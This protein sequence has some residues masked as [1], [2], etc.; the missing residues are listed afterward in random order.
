M[1][2]LSIA[3]VSVALLVLG[4]CSTT[5]TVG[6]VVPLPALPSRLAV[7]CQDPGV[8]AGNPY[9]IELANNRKALAA[10]ARKQRDTVS[11]YNDLRSRLKK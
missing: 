8:K 7:A 9:L 4:A 10:C 6:V 5:R 1:R 2:K 11:F 3:F